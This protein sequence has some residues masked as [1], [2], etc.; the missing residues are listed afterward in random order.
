MQTQSFLCVLTQ[1]KVVKEVQARTKYL[2]AKI[3]DF[4][5]EVFRTRPTASYRT[6]SAWGKGAFSKT[7][8]RAVGGWFHE[9]QGKLIFPWTLCD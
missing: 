6:Y 2:F 8:G 5:Q 1:H 3:R 7:Q 4:S 9:N